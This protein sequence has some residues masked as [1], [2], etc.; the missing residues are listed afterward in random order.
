MEAEMTRAILIA[1]AL[2]SL[3]VGGEATAGF[4]DGNGL[5]R[6]CQ[7][8]DDPRE[9]QAGD[10]GGYSEWGMCLGYILGVADAF[11]D[12]LFCLPNGVERGQIKDVVKLW[13][14]DHPEKRHLPAADL[15]AT[16]LKEKFP[17]KPQ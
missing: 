14:R 10:P 16:A 8:G 4:T 12:N 15:V 7:G 5:F 13:F 2:S 9:T 1:V 3:V 17:C 11:D 6:D